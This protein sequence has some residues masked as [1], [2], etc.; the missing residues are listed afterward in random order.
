MN[1]LFKRAFELT[2]TKFLR[3]GPGA[4]ISTNMVMGAATL[5]AESSQSAIVAFATGGQTSATK[6]T[7]EVNEVA[8]V[9]TAGDSV[10]LPTSIVGLTVYVIH[11]GAKP[12]QVFGAGTDT[13]DDVATATGVSQMPNSAVLYICSVAGK[14]RSEGLATGYAGSLQTLSFTDA[15]TAHSGGTQALA[16][17]LT[18]MVNTVTVCAAA[19]DSVA[20]PTSVAG[21]NI[22]VANQGVASLNVFTVN[23]GTDII[24]GLAAATAFAILPGQ[25]ATFNSTVA[26]KWTAP[27]TVGLPSTQLTT[28]ASGNGTLTGAQVAGADKVTLITSGATAQTTPT[29]AAILAA[30]PNGQIGQTYR[31]RIVNTNGGTLTITADAS[32]TNTGTLTLSTNTWREWDI[33][34]TGAATAT[35]KQVGTGTTS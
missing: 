15:I 2:I 21:M 12:M 25:Q 7:S 22:T 19:G 11:K 33:T 13:I 18:T 23:G 28:I 3:F 14:W 29:A 8:T 4:T 10:M 1:L 5:F 26:G 6:L 32:V 35:M 30:I 27:A 34:I 16:V 20:L 31:L 24:N 9:A 17:P